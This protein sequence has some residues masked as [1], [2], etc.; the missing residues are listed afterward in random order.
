MSAE[1]TTVSPRILVVRLGAFGDIIHALPA[2]ATLKRSFPQPRITWLVEPR[3]A[4]I[5]EG[6]P[7]IDRIVLLRRDSAAGLLESWR[8]LRAES[9]DLAI[10][11]QGLMKSALSA[12]AARPSR[13]IGFRDT[14]ESAATW[15]YSETVAASCTHVVD[16]NLELT[17]AAGATDVAREFPLPP[18]APESDLP[19]GDFVLASPLAGWP[20]K[21]WPTEFYAQLAARL[22]MPLVV[23]VSAA[24]KVS[25]PGA[26]EHVSTLPGLI[27]TTRRAAAVI[28][29][30]SG[31]MHLADALDKPGVAIFGPTD[32]AR[33]GPY[34]RSLRVLRSGSAVTTY[35]RK[36][37]I[38][39]SMRRI[40]PA[41]VLEA[42]RSALRC[43]V[44]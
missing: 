23:N 11:F 29:V 19:A 6:N 43:P 26:L 40:S 7:H 39:D 9:Y 10:D 5:L 31:P 1:C 12:A 24:G 30:D 3:W 34:N 13:T 16:R 42:L 15:F 37:S 17:A 2:V 28:G 33:N 44:R 36:S 32:P 41:E 18:G 21:Q 8:E 35:K 22:D 25:I 4:P 38:D 20:S 14:R 27:Y